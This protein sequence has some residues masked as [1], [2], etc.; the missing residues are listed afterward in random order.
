MLKLHIQ[1]LPE[2]EIN[3]FQ[4]VSNVKNL[5]HKNHYVI[6]VLSTYEVLVY[7]NYVEDHNIEN[8]I[9]ELKNNYNLNKEIYNNIKFNLNYIKNFTIYSLEE[10]NNVNIV[11]S[12]NKIN[13]IFKKFIG[14]TIEKDFFE[15]FKEEYP[16]FIKSDDDEN[17]ISFNEKN[18]NFFFFKEFKDKISQFDIPYGLVME[19]MKKNMFLVNKYLNVHELEKLSNSHIN[20]HNSIRKMLSQK[21][22]KRWRSNKKIHIL[23]IHNLEVLDENEIYEYNLKYYIKHNDVIFNIKE[24][25]TL[26][27]T[28]II[29]IRDKYNRSNEIIFQ[30][31]KE[32]KRYLMKVTK[33]I[34][35][36]LNKYIKQIDFYDKNNDIIL[37]SLNNDK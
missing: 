33:S 34:S 37:Y 4:E 29:K 1:N 2:R 6:E 22:K 3:F 32:D 11:L 26:N 10:E 20:I 28:N 35:K 8:K 5:Y 12:K 21:L 19:F 15:F 16:I 27:R 7:L 24:F 30:Y 23:N 18:Q 31:T 36:T 9:L 17:E 13:F 25:Y 14:D